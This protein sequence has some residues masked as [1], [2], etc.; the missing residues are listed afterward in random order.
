VTQLRGARGPRVNSTALRAI[1]IVAGLTQAELAS[2]AGVDGSH[3]SRLESGKRAHP[4]PRITKALA[5]VLGV[6]VATI[7]AV[8]YQSEGDQR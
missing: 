2:R 4:A 7:L 8:D 6:P 1:R 3:I 5:E